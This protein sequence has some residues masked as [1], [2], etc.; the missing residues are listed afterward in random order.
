MPA[1]RMAA[2]KM[3]GRGVESVKE[4]L[5]SKRPNIV[6]RISSFIRQGKRGGVPLALINEGRGAIN[7]PAVF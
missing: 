7:Q 1:G 4:A 2:C 6:T 3:A 5:R